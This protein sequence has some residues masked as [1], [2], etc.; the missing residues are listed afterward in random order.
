MAFIPADADFCENG[1]FAEERHIF[2]GCFGASAPVAKNLDSFAA[3]GGDRADLVVMP[4]SLATTPEAENH[5]AVIAGVRDRLATTR[6]GARLLV[7]LDE[8]PFVQRMPP[9]RVAERREAWRKFVQA[10]G[11]EPAFASLEP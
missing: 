9:E 8:A 4:F 10:H 5:G 2:P 7:V 11:L 6:P 3:R 1:H